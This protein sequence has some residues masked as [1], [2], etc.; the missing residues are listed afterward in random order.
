MLALRR[1]VT[2]RKELQL[3]FGFD[4]IDFYK[5][6]HGH[7]YSTENFINMVEQIEKTMKKE[8]PIETTNIRK[9]EFKITNEE[10]KQLKDL[11]KNWNERFIKQNDEQKDTFTKIENLL[12][13]AIQNG[14]LDRFEKYDY[15]DTEQSKTL[16]KL[17][18]NKWDI[19][20]LLSHAQSELEGYSYKT[21]QELTKLKNELNKKVTKEFNQGKSNTGEFKQNLLQLQEVHHQLNIREA[22]SK[23]TGINLDKFGKEYVLRLGMEPKKQMGLLREEVSTYFK[24]NEG[25]SRPGN[26]FSEQ[27]NTKINNGKE[28]I[29]SIYNELKHFDNKKDWKKVNACTKKLM[30]E[31]SQVL[32]ENTEIL[33]VYYNSNITK[34]SNTLKKLGIKNFVIN[35]NDEPSLKKQVSLE[36]TVPKKTEQHSLEEDISSI[37]SSEASNTVLG[38]DE[39][40]PLDK[41]AKTIKELT[42]HKGGPDYLRKRKQKLNK[43]ISEAY[44]KGNIHTE[45][46][47]AE[48][49]QLLEVRHQLTLRKELQSIFG[50]DVMDFYVKSVK[51][52]NN[53]NIKNYIKMI[54][55]IE[56]ITGKVQDNATERTNEKR[57]TFELSK[58]E[59]KEFQKAI[60]N[61]NTSVENGSNEAFV[62]YELDQKI[63][64]AIE[65]GVLDRFKKYHYYDVSQSKTLTNLG[66]N[67]WDIKGLLSYSPEPEIE[68]RMDSYSRIEEKELKRRKKEAQKMLKS[69]VNHQ[70]RLNP[71]DFNYY[72]VDLREI[73]YQQMIRKAITKITGI[74]IDKFGKEYISR[75]GIRPNDKIDLWRSEVSAI[76]KENEESMDR[77]G[78][79]EEEKQKIEDGKKKIRSIYNELKQFDKKKD[80]ENVNACTQKLMAEID[81]VVETNTKII[82]KEYN[83]DTFKIDKV[84]QTTFEDFSPRKEVQHQFKD[85]SLHEPKI[86]NRESIAGSPLPEEKTNNEPFIDNYQR[87]NLSHLQ[88]RKEE[89]T[90]QIKEKLQ[91]MIDLVGDKNTRETNVNEKNI[92]ELRILFSELLHGDLV[93]KVNDL[94]RERIDLIKEMKEKADQ[95]RETFKDDIKIYNELNYVINFYNEHFSIENSSTDPKEQIDRIDEFT[96]YT[97]KLKEENGPNILQI[98]WLANNGDKLIDIKEHMEEIDLLEDI[99]EDLIKEDAPEIPSKLNK[100]QSENIPNPMQGGNEKLDVVTQVRKNTIDELKEKVSVDHSL[101]PMNQTRVNLSSVPQKNMQELT[102]PPVSP[103]VQTERKQESLDKKMEALRNMGRTQRRQAM[104]KIINRTV[105]V[106]QS[107]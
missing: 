26:Q 29:L 73:R 52:R 25:D 2:I 41:Q 50:F 78:F 45:L 24:A 75:L 38:E 63:A 34:R 105:E 9:T 70:S 102:A 42:D 31:I 84:V 11:N 69:G 12:T 30:T 18:L 94:I 48:L 97:E 5:E 74:E 90:V 77:K 80:W 47:K 6:A 95:L 14:A 81:Y 44:K 32:N 20:G 87:D 103:F 107:M 100:G 46:T 91:E 17:G 36:E 35:L 37:I 82:A 51:E 3:I 53:L 92:E 72:S 23:M 58:V 60:K 79:S 56:K 27:E 106:E 83:F 13:N 22:I 19:K 96:K 49:R 43:N 67:K 39:P 1:Q 10:K 101:P 28:A 59:K 104:M 86:E 16:T 76:F 8:Y 33:A 64:R 99:I 85:T 54:E 21:D 65:N 55:Q 62:A 15:Y 88:N 93:T 89:L 40:I 4:V 68:A 71:K 98:R 66:L 57:A 61:W 7:R